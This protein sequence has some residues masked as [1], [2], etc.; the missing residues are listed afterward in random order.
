MTVLAIDIGTHL[1]WFLGDA[2]GPVEYGTFELENTPD[3]G[4]WL[5]SSD[6]F[7]QSVLPKTRAIAIEKPNTGSGSGFFAVRK[8]VALLG[9]CWYWAHFYGINGLNEVSVSTGKLTLTGHGH[10]DK[11]AMIKA[12]AEDGYEDMDEH[13]ADAYGIWKTHVFGRREPIKRPP[14]N[15]KVTIIKP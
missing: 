7:F 3:L 9:H 11:A 12:A 13:A 2:V 5:A 8:N 15:S 6:A 4:K 1:G 10:A 14:K